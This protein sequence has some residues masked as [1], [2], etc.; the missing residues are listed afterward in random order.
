M[1][2]TSLLTTLSPTDVLSNLSVIIV[3]DPVLLSVPV[4][5]V[6]VWKSSKIVVVRDSVQDLTWL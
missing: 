4:L 3:L 5:N 1:L 6:S 2:I